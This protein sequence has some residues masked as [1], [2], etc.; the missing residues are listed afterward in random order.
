M[1]QRVFVLTGDSPEIPGG[2]EHAV[3]ELIKGLETRGYAV[4]TFHRHNVSAPGWVSSPTNKWQG[5]GADVLISWYLGLRVRERMGKDVAA[6]VSNG[7]FGWY[8]PDSHHSL[9]KY[10]FITE[11]IVVRRMKFARLSRRLEPLS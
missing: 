7:P 9:K 4:E 8:A 6:V 3:R 1:K 2:M 11:L 5:Y 10:I